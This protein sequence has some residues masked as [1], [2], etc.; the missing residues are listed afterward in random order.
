MKE[1]ADK[2]ADHVA[3]ATSRAIAKIADEFER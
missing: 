1:H 3:A 2:L